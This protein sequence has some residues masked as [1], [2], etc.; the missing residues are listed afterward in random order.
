VR[1]E[2]LKTYYPGLCS[3][4]LSKIAQLDRLE[5]E[6]GVEV[7]CRPATALRAVVKGLPGF[8]AHRS[9]LQAI[10]HYYGGPPQIPEILC[11]ASAKDA[12]PD[13][14]WISHGRSSYTTSGTLPANRITKIA[15]AA[16]EYGIDIENLGSSF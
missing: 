15:F 16:P 7:T 2:P 6:D 13:F 3:G 5:N 4:N 12:F 10:R 8:Q 14:L 9:D 11:L 1:G